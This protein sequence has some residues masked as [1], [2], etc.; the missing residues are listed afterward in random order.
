MKD[1]KSVSVYHNNIDFLQVVS[2]NNKTFERKDTEQ[3]CNVTSA[4]F[5]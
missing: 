2:C 4:N 3:Y 5:M 1:L